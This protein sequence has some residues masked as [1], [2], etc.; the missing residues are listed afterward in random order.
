MGVCDVA[1]ELLDSA[2]AGLAGFIGRYFSGLRPYH[3]I[4]GES[5]LGENSMLPF[6]DKS[7]RHYWLT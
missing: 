7:P 6:F 3:A 4:G 2:S 5:R 1:A